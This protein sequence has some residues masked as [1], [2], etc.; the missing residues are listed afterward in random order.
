MPSL[1]RHQTQRFNSLRNV[2]FNL[3]DLIGYSGNDR[4][5]IYNHLQEVV[6]RGNSF[7]NNLVLLKNCSENQSFQRGLII[8]KI[9]SINSVKIYV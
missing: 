8:K 2:A 3:W 9:V 4:W 6:K 7:Q 1:S 5:H